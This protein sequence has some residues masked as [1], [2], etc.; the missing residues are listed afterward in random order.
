M[1]VSLEWR[2]LG[3]EYRRRDISHFFRVFVDN[4]K[5][6]LMLMITIFLILVVN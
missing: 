1:Y 2:V 4:D 3:G 5:Y 6:K